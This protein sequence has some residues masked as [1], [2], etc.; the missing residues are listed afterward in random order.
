MPFR[1]TAALPVLDSR[2]LLAMEASSRFVKV[3]GLKAFLG[4]RLNFTAPRAL[5]ECSSGR[6]DKVCALVL[7]RFAGQGAWLGGQNVATACG[8]HLHSLKHSQRS[9]RA[10]FDFCLIT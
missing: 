7:H 6:Q 10:K 1:P 4:V 8:S 3:F 9:Y 2:V 5:I